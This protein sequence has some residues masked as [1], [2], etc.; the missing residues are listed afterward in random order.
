MSVI[1][2]CPSCKIDGSTTA[3]AAEITIP[4]LYNIDPAQKEIGRLLSTKNWVSSWSMS[5]YWR[6]LLVVQLEQYS[7]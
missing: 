7:F 6:V 3:L 2:Q 4:K 5:T 1:D